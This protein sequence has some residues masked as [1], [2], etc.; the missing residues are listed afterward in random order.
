MTLGQRI[1]YF[2]EESGFSQK[3]LGEKI[4][5]SQQQLAQYEN[6]KRKPKLQTVQRIAEALNIDFYELIDGGFGALDPVLPP[7]MQ[8]ANLDGAKIDINFLN[9]MLSELSYLDKADPKYKRTRDNIIALA[10]SSGMGEYADNIIQKL[11]NEISPS[12]PI[13]YGLED[14][15]EISLILNYRKLNTDGKLKLLEASEDYT[16]IEKYTKHDC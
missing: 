12:F 8:G 2:R 15:L 6:D 5:M 13:L 1:K 3:K 9:S 7:N 14:D 4:G 11:E 16:Y 10:T